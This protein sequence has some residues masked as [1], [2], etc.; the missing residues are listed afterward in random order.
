MGNEAKAQSKFSWLS[1]NDMKNVVILIET[2]PYASC[3]HKK[4]LY[5]ASY[6]FL[7]TITIQIPDEKPAHPK[8]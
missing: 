5:I 7:M 2:P 3:N 8:V 4:D 1:H 6:L